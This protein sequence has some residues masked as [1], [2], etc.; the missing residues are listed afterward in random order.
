MGPW[1]QGQLGTY[2]LNTPIMGNQSN[3]CMAKFGVTM[4]SF[5][6]AEVCELVGLYLLSLLCKHFNKDQT[7]LYR[8]YGLAVR[9][10]SG[11]QADRARNDLCDIFRS[12]GLRV[13]VDANWLP[14]R[15][16]RPVIG[17]VLAL[18]ETQWRTP[19]HPCKVQSSSQCPKKLAIH[20][21]QQ[22]DLYIMQ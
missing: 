13:T 3:A 14:R 1:V 6:G 10:L 20:D 16:F 21:R 5:D 18:Q 9:K 11:P 2:S 8:Y 17:Q 4:G 22:T 15:H 12:C 19:L 7:G